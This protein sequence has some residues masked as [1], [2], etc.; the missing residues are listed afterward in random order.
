MIV[1]PAVAVVGIVIGSLLLISGARGTS[2]ASANPTATAI[3]SATVAP[4][5]T[6]IPT[7]SPSPTPTT[8]AGSTPLPAGWVYAPLD[9]VATTAALAEY[10]STLGVTVATWSADVWIATDG[11]YPVSMDILATASD[12]SVAYEIKFDI[13]NVN[14]P[15]NKVT[16]PTNVTG[17]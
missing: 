10:G 17:M 8:Y 11:G 12:N 9:G 13:T 1:T 16:A 2:Q 4:T 15:A 3:A 14:D 5:D 7:P 6:P